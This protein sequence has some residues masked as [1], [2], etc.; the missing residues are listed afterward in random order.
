MWSELH[1]RPGAGA[2]VAGEVVDISAPR[3]AVRIGVLRRP[4]QDSR[5]GNRNRP[6]EPTTSRVGIGEGGSWHGGGTAVQI[7]DMSAPSVRRPDVVNRR[8]DDDSCPGDG[9]RPAEI[10]IRP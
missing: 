1:Q 6:A 3:A 5:A 10:V 9:H 4:D 2:G 8:G 7:I